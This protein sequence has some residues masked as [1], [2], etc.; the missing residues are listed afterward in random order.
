[1]KRLLA[2]VFH[3]ACFLCFKSKLR[4]RGSLSW[5]FSSHKVVC[6]SAVMPDSVTP[7]TVARQAPLSMGFPRQAYWSGLSLPSPRDLPN[8]GIKPKSPVSATLAGRVYTTEP[9]EN[10]VRVLIAKEIEH[11][12]RDF[13]LQRA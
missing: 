13:L 5:V 8:T 9:P 7:Q 1:M 6:V 2:S 10:P 12:S 11:Y 4:T 3:F